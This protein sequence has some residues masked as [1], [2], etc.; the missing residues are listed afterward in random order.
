MKSLH[1]RFKDFAT[2]AVS[3]PRAGFMAGGALLWAF[4]L[5]DAVIA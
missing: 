4:R 3:E 5:G 2:R 1:G